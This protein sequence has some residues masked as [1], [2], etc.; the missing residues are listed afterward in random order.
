MRSWQTTAATWHGKRVVLGVV[1]AMTLGAATTARAQ[2][3]GYTASLFVSRAT[4]P[5]DTGRTTS[6]YVFNS[7]DIATGRIRA[8]VSLPFAW[9]HSTF[10]VSTTDSAMNTPGEVIE[11]ATGVGDPLLRADVTV[12]DDRSLGLQLTVAGS[13]KLPL[14]SPDDGLGTGETDV[15]VGGSLFSAQGKTSLFADVMF[16]KYG[17]PEGVNFEDSLSYSVGFGRVIGTG[18]WSAMTALAGF[19]RGIDGQAGPLQLNLTMLAL[20]GRRQSVAI[21]AGAGLNQ[22]SRGFTVGTSWRITR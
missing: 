22:A 10:P 4:Y 20:A 17:D 5:A 3:L 1:C 13:V 11:T 9:R 18:R 15:G 6:V 14:A 8:S 16:W 2:D 19:S 7:V 21:T 12:L